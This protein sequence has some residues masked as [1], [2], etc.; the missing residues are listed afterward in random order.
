MARQQRATA[1]QAFVSL[2]FCDS[3]VAKA[4][5]DCT[6]LCLCRDSIHLCRSCTG[7]AAHQLLI[8]SM[9][10]C[11]RCIR[12]MDARA[13]HHASMLFF[14]EVCAEDEDLP[15]LQTFLTTEAATLAGASVITK[16]QAVAAIQ[17]RHSGP[18]DAVPAV[19]LDRR[20]PLPPPG[21]VLVF[22]DVHGCA[23][24]HRSHLLNQSLFFAGVWVCHGLARRRCAQVASTDPSEFYR[25]FFYSQAAA[26]CP[27]WKPS[28]GYQ[29]RGT[30]CLPNLS[31]SR[32]N[33]DHG[34]G[35]PYRADGARRADNARRE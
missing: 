8:R 13:Q 23:S 28:I 26:A 33:R 10:C 32:Y 25:I 35:G 2:P 31:G 7:H 4:R 29:S 9:P 34:T 24:D 17:Q 5:F 15:E 21:C 27:R 16:V 12:Q 19:P 6:N 11:Q 14:G 18:T 22:T 30:V 20:P 1:I 3:T